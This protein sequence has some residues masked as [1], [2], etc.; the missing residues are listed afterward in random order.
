MAQEQIDLYSGDFN[1]IGTLHFS[2]SDKTIPGHTTELS[3]SVKLFLNKAGYKAME[4]ACGWAGATFEV[5]R[6]FGQEQ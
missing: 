2:Y 4:V 1:L 6:P 3:N 5:T